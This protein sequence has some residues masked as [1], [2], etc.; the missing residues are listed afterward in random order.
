MV[1]DKIMPLCGDWYFS[2]Q[3]MYIHEYVQVLIS[4]YLSRQ[5]RMPRMCMKIEA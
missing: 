5:E 2:H 4:N 3:Y 1:L